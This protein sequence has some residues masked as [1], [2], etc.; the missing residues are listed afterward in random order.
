MLQQIVDNRKKHIARNK[1]LYPVKLLESSMYFDSKVVSLSQHITREDKTGIIA[2]FKRKSPS[3]G[4]IN[5]YADVL[6]TTI[7]YMQAGASALSILTEPDYFMG[8]DGDLKIARNANYCPILR[9]DFIVDAY[10]VIETKSI[11]ADAILLFAA[12]LEKGVLKDLYQLARS[13]GLEV[14]FEIHS[15]EELSKLPGD[16]LMIGV[17]NRDLKTMAVNIQTSFDIAKSL[18]KDFVL[19]AESGLS[20]AE[21]IIRLKE[22]GYSGFLMGEAFMKTPKPPETLELLVEKLQK[23]TA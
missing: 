8:K 2:E 18:S 10:Q 13:L 9:K 7:G 4:I 11:G 21:D 16:E 23:T 3:K 6:D 20:A 15:A 19:V 12:C 1:A 5:P 14:L 22:A 17:N